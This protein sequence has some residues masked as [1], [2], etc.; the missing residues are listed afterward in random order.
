MRAVSLQHLPLP[1]VESK[2]VRLFVLAVCVV[3]SG[4]FVRQ[5]TLNPKSVLAPP[6]VQ[7][8][9]EL[10]QRLTEA[11]TYA[12]QQREGTIL[13]V[14]PQ[15]GRIRTVI[16][17]QIAFERAFAPGSTIK[18]FAALA[19]LR[20]GLISRD[21]RVLCGE[22]YDHAGFKTVCSHPL[23]LGPFNPA[24]A[25]AYS[26]NY[27]F[28]RLGE[29]LSEDDFRA[30]LAQFGFGAKTRINHDA[31]SVGLLAHGVWHPE[32]VLG[33]GQ[34][35]QA[36]PVQLL[37]AYSALVNGGQLL[38]PQVASPD[39]FQ[40]EIR[41][42]INIS[43]DQR[44]VII[45]GLRGAI[46]FGTAERTELDTLPIYIIGKTGTSTPVNG[47]RTQ[48]WFVGFAGSKPDQFVT[49]SLG[50]LVFLKR[51]HG[52]DA[53]LVSRAVF[54]EYARFMNTHAAVSHT[55]SL[56]G[57]RDSETA[58][59][60][61]PVVRVHLTRENRTITVP[62]ED[63]VLG[64][65]STE[66]SL[67]TEPEALKALAVATRT[68]ALHNIGRHND[69]GYDFCTLTHCQRF[70]P[71]EQVR[72]LVR[73]AVTQ[74]QGEVLRT[75]DGKLADSYF[76]ASCGGQ[77][78]NIK[79]LW[80]APPEPE[81]N[82]VTD[83]YCDSMPH[84]HWSDV[85]SSRDLLRAMRS[86]PRTDVGDE[87]KDIVV[88][89]RDQTGRAEFVTIF[90]R[91]RR[92]VRGWDFKIIV[93]R[94]LGWNL[95]KSSRFQISRAGSD[96]VFHGSGFG[97]GLGLCQEG[98]HVMSERGFNYRQILSKYFPG[99]VVMGRLKQ[100]LK[101]DVLWSA[102]GVT[103]NESSDAIRTAGRAARLRITSEHFEVNYPSTLK[104]REAED[105]LKLLE[106]S[107]DALLHRPFLPTRIPMPFIQVFVNETTG[108]FV[109]RTGL[110]WWAAAASDGNRIELQPIVL[111]KRRGVL[112]TTVRHELVHRMIDIAGKGRTPRWLA[113]G[114]ALHLA[115]EG[116][117]I[118]RVKPAQRLS[119]RELDQRLATVRSSDEMRELY[120]S[121]YFEVR[122]LIR[123]GGEAAVWQRVL[124][125]ED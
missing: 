45:E 51:G 7:F 82:G 56:V 78:A 79:L 112:E 98:A 116:P 59:S 109:G 2:H 10:D 15:T 104:R 77:T 120:A 44:D 37:M 48:G 3:T 85:I 22:K 96:Y 68:Y 69:E 47:F 25:I 23:H 73:S 6:P 111:L 62:L 115:G 38:R 76:S 9:R 60:V 43:K 125:G 31:E 88:S 74:T 65:V 75:K 33:E 106:V 35:I 71:A 72:D 19:A 99:S 124:K 93:G 61:E 90:G 52:K 55:E 110:A 5:R 66:G 64:V 67:E 14:D 122:R 28:A 27:Y 103:S 24:E 34:Y 94:A 117:L 119:V 53:A 12:L 50:V 20:A 46:H 58:H 30:T 80:E 70:F 54:E 89:T 29:R 87:L 92:T 4:L 41:T 118:S 42:T 21:S 39:Q 1:R 86:D 17:P 100:D 108:D 81:L 32:N 26:C 113:E 123:K 105:L 95:L 13:V 101:A 107:R 18:P 97:H 40:R 114:L 57:V 16:N 8:E 102:T 36:T 91:Q 11:A 83:Q 121:A 49:P 84:A 63:Y